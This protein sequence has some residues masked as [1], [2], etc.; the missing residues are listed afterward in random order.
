[1]LSLWIL[2]LPEHG[3]GL[4]FELIN[5]FIKFDDILIMLNRVIKHH[6]SWKHLFNIDAVAKFPILFEAFRFLTLAS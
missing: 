2:G 3:D 1:M 6:Y 4:D 5:I